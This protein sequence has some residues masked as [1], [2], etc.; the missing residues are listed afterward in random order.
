M[1]GWEPP[2]VMGAIVKRR[3]KK[4]YE[5]HGWGPQLT[6]E[7]RR[8]DGTRLFI[9]LRLP[10]TVQFEPRP[11]DAVRPSEVVASGEI[12]GDGEPLASMTVSFEDG[13]VPKPEDYPEP[14]EPWAAQQVKVLNG[15]AM[16]V[17]RVSNQPKL[18][19]IYPFTSQ[20]G[21]LV[22]TFATENQQMMGPAA[23]EICSQIVETS[24]IGTKKRP[25]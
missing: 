24:W 7:T 12:V 5:D 4:I 11:S 18:E 6:F 20:F 10:K 23:R 14:G 16:T 1:P 25:Y 9:Q 15:R 2:T 13:R 17:M 21:A 8:T 22:Y 19:M 3:I